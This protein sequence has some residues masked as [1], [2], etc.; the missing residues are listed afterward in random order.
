VRAGVART[1]WRDGLATAAD[2]ALVGIAVTLA[3]APLVTAG[4]AV[5]TGSLAARRIVDGERVPPLGE[6]WRVFRR[7]VLPG[8]AAAAVLL[9]VAALLVVDLV[10]LSS[11]RVP[12]G[13]PAIALTAC[14][15]AAVAAVAALTVARL[16]SDVDCGW[17]AALRW[18]GGTA[19]RRPVIAAGVVGVLALAVALAV[20]VPATAPL[21]VGFTLYAIHVV[22]R[23][24]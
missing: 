24:A 23:R 4:A 13:L 10:A 7:A 9:A 16:G 5:R 21:V 12:G 20:L 2:L 22:A 18:A 1:D 3:A 8:L 11:G 15:A 14:V 19:R 17:L 6:L